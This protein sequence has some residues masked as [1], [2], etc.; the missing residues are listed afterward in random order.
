[1]TAK[2]GRKRK[3]ITPEEVE[4]AKLLASGHGPVEAYRLVFKGKCE[5]GTSE[6]QKA[7][8]LARSERV[9]KAVV[10]LKKKIEEDSRLAKSLAETNDLNSDSIR[11]FLYNHLIAIRDDPTKKAQLKLQAIKILE[12]LHNPAE[13]NNLILKW[14]DLSWRYQKA[15]CPCCHKDFPLA[16][17][18]NEALDEYRKKNEIDF[19]YE[20]NTDY[21]RQLNLIKEASP[22][23]NP[24]KSQQACLQAPERH[25]IGTAAARTGKSYLL[26]LF[27]L[28]GL[29]IPGV[30]IWFIARTYSD[31]EKEVE[32]LKQ[33]LNTLFSPYTNKV[34]KDYHDNKTKEYHL[35]TRWGSRLTIRSVKSKGSLTAHPLELALVAEPG[36]I[37][38]DIFNHLRARM[39]ERLGRIIALGTPQDAGGFLSRMSKTFGKDEHGRMIRLKPEERLIENGCPWNVSLFK[40]KLNPRDN[41]EYVKSEL[42]AA[43]LELTEEEYATEFGGEEG[44]LTGRKFHQIN[45]FHLQRIPP[46]FFDRAVF[47]LGIDQGLRNF[48]G[49]LTAFDGNLIVPCYEYFDNSYTTMKTNL[50]D[51]RKHVPSWILKLGGNPEHWLLTVTDVDPPLYGTF[52]EMEEQN[53]LKWPTDI[54]LR[55]R[56]NVRAGDNWREDTTEFINNLAKQHKLLFHESPIYSSD[57]TIYPGSFFLHE[58][59]KEILNAEKDRTKESKSDNSK[60]WL[61]NDIRSDHVPDAFMFTMYTILSEQLTYPE[62]LKFAHSNTNAWQEQQKALETAIALDERQELMG[63]VHRKELPT[64]REV[65]ERNM[66]RTSPTVGYTGHYRDES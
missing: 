46:D 10:E 55:H 43:H 33:F 65:Y 24:H 1:M 26:A 49:C 36:W 44:Q 45:D 54:T 38:G 66:G 48:A 32:Y 42:E 64:I 40:I 35:I 19:K 12:R 51:L 28:L 18:K 37:Q 27:A 47:V 16:E 57:P 20:A 9:K 15:H 60:F 14:L 2:G 7:R 34:Y 22:R 21:Q 52:L 25:L 62:S 58:Q 50:V 29:L 30:E 17:V 59:L 8:D 13:D 4:F 5:P 6:S 61:V 56:N 39:S 41:P 31:A 3:S 11:K 63:Y 23:R 53:N